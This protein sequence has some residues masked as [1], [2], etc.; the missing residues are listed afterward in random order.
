MTTSDKAAEYELLTRRLAAELSDFYGVLTRRCEVRVVL[1]G[2]GTDN[3]IDVVWEGVIGGVEQRILIECKHY[4]RRVDQGKLH[5]FHSV[6]EDIVKRDGIPTV[7]VFV[8]TTGY[9]SGAQSLA[10]AYDIVVLELRPPTPEDLK[11]RVTQIVYELVMRTEVVRDVQVEAEWLGDPPANSSVAVDPAT[12][13]VEFPDGTSTSLRETLTAGECSPLGQRPTPPHPVSRHFSAQTFLRI[14]GERALEVRRISATVGDSDS[15][16]RHTVGPG[17]E[18]IA[19][20]MRDAVSGS[21]VWFEKNGTI[22]A[23]A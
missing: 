1:P 13:M 8:T 20:V 7:G 18:G 14:D 21:T 19:H 22:H 6:V 23:V 9:Q 12:T 10:T 17:P 2:Y 3:E 5:T 15:R 16:A 4:K 11:G